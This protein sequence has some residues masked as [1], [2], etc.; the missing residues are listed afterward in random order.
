MGN[1][2]RMRY[3]PV[4]RSAAA[5]LVLLGLAAPARGAGELP[6]WS[7]GASRVTPFER[8]TSHIASQLAGSDVAVECVT[9]GGWQMLSHRYGFDRASTLALTPLRRESE[10][11]LVPTGRSLFSPRACSL[12]QAFWLAP[13]EPGSRLCDHGYRLVGEC[14]DW[15]AKL[16]AVHI[17]GH[18]SMHLSGVVDEAAAECLSTQLGAF[19]ATRLGAPRGFSRSLAA[20]YWRYYYRDQD[21]RYLSP[22][23]R[24][25][26]TLDLFPGRVG[27]PTPVSYPRDVHAAIDRFVALDSTAHSTP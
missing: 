27:W 1:W 5:C 17:L 9:R 18:E 7:G 2:G 6:P 3:S 16:L 10:A 11:A 26:G 23:C 13:S 22:A 4:W 19:V 12:A 21:P 24:S 8:S 20:E 15:A 14:D 25:G